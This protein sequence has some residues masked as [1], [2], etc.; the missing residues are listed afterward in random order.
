MDGDVNFVWDR[1]FDIYHIHRKCALSVLFLG[2]NFDR[3]INTN[4][5]EF[6]FNSAKGMQIKNLVGE[7]CR[8][9]PAFEVVGLEPKRGTVL[10]FSSHGEVFRVFRNVESVLTNVTIL[11]LVVWKVRVIDHVHQIAPVHV[12]GLRN[13][14]HVDA[15]NDTGVF[16]LVVDKYFLGDGLRH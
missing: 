3:S 4:I 5:F 10:I 2:R 16:P 15:S 9:E 11:E 7:I 14:I 1:D 6:G 13:N 8:S 12:F